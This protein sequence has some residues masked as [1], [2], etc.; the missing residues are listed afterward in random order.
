MTIEDLRGGD[1]A[2]NAD[3]I[4]R[5]VAGEA[6]PHRD[7]AVLNA[8]ASLVVIGKATDLKEGVELAV[9]VIDNGSAERVLNDFVSTTRYAHAEEQ[10]AR[11][12]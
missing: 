8:A 11:G 7:V 4:R 1:A 12:A 2:Y 6:S 10:A 9:S 3:V 5:V